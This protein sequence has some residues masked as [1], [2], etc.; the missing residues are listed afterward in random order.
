MKPSLKIVTLHIALWVGWMPASQ[1]QAQIPADSS[2]I[3]SEPECQRRIAIDFGKSRDELL[4]YIQRYYPQ[5]TDSM[6]TV[7]ETDGSLEMKIIDGKKRYFSQAARNLFRIN[8]DAR[9]R[10][11]QIDGA[12]PLSG[13]NKVNALHLPEVM[14]A[15]RNESGRP[16]MP[17]TM[18]VDYTV[19]VKKSA[20]QPG[21]TLRCW[22]PYPREEEKRQQNIELIKTS[23]SDYQIAPVEAQQ[24][25]IYMEQVVEQPEAVVF[26]YTLRYTSSP[27]WH[28][29]NPASIQP[30]DTTTA[31]YKQYTAERKPHIRFSDRM[32]KLADSLTMGETNP[33]LQARRIFEYI[34]T[35]YPWASARE[36]ST[37]PDIPHYVVEQGHGD[38][39]MVSLLFI[40]LCRIKGIPAKWQS[41]FMMHP[42]AVNLHDWSEIWLEGIGWIPVD[43]SFG[44]ADYL[45]DKSGRLFYASGIDAYRMIVNNDYSQPLVPRKRFTRS[46][47]VDFQRGEVETQRGNLYFNEWNW[48]MDVKYLP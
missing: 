16:D 7:W 19:T 12:E 11:E 27:E 4:P 39:G 20:L 45:N 28:D 41:G 25:S 44:V 31:F 22:L 1:L 17:V 30:Y 40:T 21:D 34:D 29:L 8:K 6:L 10:K 3:I 47:T 37:V 5:V 32:R 9:L 15:P 24:R 38:C 35:T 14:R 42:E 13:Y 23:Q 46:E 48:H 33:L 36:Y 43:V 18:E 26:G 2:L